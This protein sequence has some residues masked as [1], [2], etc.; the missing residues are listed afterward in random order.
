[1]RWFDCSMDEAIIANCMAEEVWHE[2]TPAQ[3]ESVA[4][5]SALVVIP[6]EKIQ[7]RAYVFIE[8]SHRYVGVFDPDVMDVT[9][10]ADGMLTEAEQLSVYVLE[11]TSVVE[12]YR[13][14]V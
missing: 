6:D 2:L 9:V 1:M 7:R 13:V 8:P 14:N 4:K 5:A 12:S 10:L 11:N 3:R